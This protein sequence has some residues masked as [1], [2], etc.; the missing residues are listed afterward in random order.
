MGSLEH[1]Q[2]LEGVEGGH[3]MEEA[4]QVEE[5]VQY[6][7]VREA[8]EVEEEEQ[9]PQALG[10][11]VEAQKGMLMKVLSVQYEQQTD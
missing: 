3:Q 2:T 9:V 11:G 4:L 7:Q 10:H 6:S 8:E 5:V 1:P